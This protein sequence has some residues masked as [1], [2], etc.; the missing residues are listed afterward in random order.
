MDLDRNLLA[1]VTVLS[2]AAGFVFAITNNHPWYLAL[3][4]AVLLMAVYLLGARI[5][6]SLQKG[7]RSWAYYGKPAPDEGG[8][9]MTSLI[10]PLALVPV[11]VCYTVLGLVNRLFAEKDL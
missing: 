3:G 1:S 11:L 8:A 2:G 6:F 5:S 4:F 10:W 7:I 9:L